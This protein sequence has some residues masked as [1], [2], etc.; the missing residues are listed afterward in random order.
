MMRRLSLLG[1]VLHHGP[2]FRG[3]LSEVVLQ[4]VAVL[5]QASDRPADV[6][7]ADTV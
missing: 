6:I 1:G 3:R 4:L 7:R 2:D 5:L